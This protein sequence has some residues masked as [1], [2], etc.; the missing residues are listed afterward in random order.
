MAC[1][2][3]TSVSSPSW[4]T[5]SCGHMIGN[6]RYSI[7]PMIDWDTFVS[8][9]K[10]ASTR[11]WKIIWDGTEMPWRNRRRKEVVLFP[12]V[13]SVSISRCSHFVHSWV[14]NTTHLISLDRQR[15]TPISMTTGACNDVSSWQVKADTRSL[16]IARWMIKAC[17]TSGGSNPKRIRCSV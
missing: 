2:S 10:I 5:T 13:G 11:G 4:H 9:T 16:R 6:S 15:V 1:A 17:T 3:T 8:F 7:S 12:S 14:T